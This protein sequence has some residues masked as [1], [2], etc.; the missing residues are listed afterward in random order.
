MCSV[1]GLKS[2]YMTN[3]IIWAYEYKKEDLNF[4]AFTTFL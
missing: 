2:N 4:E 3:L 1:A